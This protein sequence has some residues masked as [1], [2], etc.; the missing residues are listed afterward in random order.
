V[1]TAPFISD[2][3]PKDEDTNHHDCAENL[4]HALRPPRPDIIKP[5]SR[6]ATLAAMLDLL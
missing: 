2:I 6:L 3:A 4:H 1:H 5:P